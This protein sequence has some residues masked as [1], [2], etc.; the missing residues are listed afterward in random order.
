MDRIGKSNQRGPLKE[1]LASVLHHMS[2]YRIKHVCYGYLGYRLL[3]K[4]LQDMWT[5][6][7]ASLLRI[8]NN[9]HTP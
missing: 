7:P 4:A 3:W 9:R 5:A 6:P 2:M 8:K 1:Q